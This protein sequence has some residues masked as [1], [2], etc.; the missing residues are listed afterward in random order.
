LF[1]LPLTIQGEWFAIKANTSPQELDFGT[2]SL[3]EEKKE[4]ISLKNEGTSPFNFHVSSK[5]G[6]F[7]IT[8][9][10]GLLE[11][12]EDITLEVVNSN[13]P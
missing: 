13:K 12:Q 6:L 3:R 9:S 10:K 5:R 11:P 4:V 8:P 1:E 7:L 2:M